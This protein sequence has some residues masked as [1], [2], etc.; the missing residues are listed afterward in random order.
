MMRTTVATIYT[1]LLFL[2]CNNDVHGQ[3]IKR[4]YNNLSAVQNTLAQYKTDTATVHNLLREVFGLERTQ[5]DSALVIHAKALQ[6]SQDI[7]YNDGMYYALRGIGLCYSYMGKYEKSIFYY[8]RAII[9]ALQSSKKTLLPKLYHLMATSY[10]YQGKYDLSIYYSYKFLIESAQDPSKY[11]NAIV[12]TYANIGSMWIQMGDTSM[13]INFLKKGEALAISNKDSL[14]LPH[15]YC[16]LASVYSEINTEKAL[17]Y[18]QKTLKYP[19]DISHVGAYNYIGTYYGRQGNLN[20]SIKCFNKAILIAKDIKIFAVEPKSYFSLGQTYLYYKKYKKAENALL[21]ALKK[22]ETSDG[23]AEFMYIHK[24]LAEVYNKTG[25]YEKAYSYL[26]T[27]TQLYNESINEKS[28]KMLRQ[29]EVKF[30]TLEKDKEIL[31]QQNKLAQ[32]NIWIG[33]VSASALLLISLLSSLYRSNRHKQQVQTKQIQILKQEQKIGQL[34]SLMEGEEKERARIAR[35]LHDGI[36]SKLAT[37]KM[38]FSAFQYQ[39]K[40]QL[41]NN[42]DLNDILELLNDTCSE[43]RETA[44]NLMP[45]ILSHYGLHEALKIY[46]ESINQAHR[47]YVDLQMHG[48]FEI[49]NKSFSLSVYRIVQEL[50]QNIIKHAEATH[51]LVQINEHNNSLTLLVEDNGKG[52][53]DYLQKK[54]MGMQNILSR[55]T[56]HHGNISIHGEAQKGTVVYIKFDLDKSNLQQSI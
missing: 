29:E 13:A 6:I 56:I 8:Q 20:E 38:N 49:L 3:E 22:S 41:P 27:Y 42:K 21:T 5:P 43:V 34:K 1:L 51:T 28:W 45:V 9:C 40:Q 16:N 55:V 47:L 33:S 48:N 25:E 2:I 50:L 53:T 7:Q 37:L 52:Y 35:E 4:T 23:K 26:D 32:K 31:R 11:G 15:I 10:S 54:G 18:A 39:Y 30:K 17:Y 14:S 19:K 46:C 36:G 24:L 12:T 44:H